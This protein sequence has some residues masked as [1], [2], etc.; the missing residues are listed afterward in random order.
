MSHFLQIGCRDIEPGL[1]PKG[2]FRV[3]ESH[4]IG[5]WL[6]KIGVHGLK[7]LVEPMVMRGGTLNRLDQKRIRHLLP[8]LS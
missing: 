3:P 4:S 6:L 5:L 2:G 8:A 1:T 7:L